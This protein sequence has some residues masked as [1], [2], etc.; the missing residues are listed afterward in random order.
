MTE[1]NRLAEVIF[2]IGRTLGER[3]LSREGDTRD[4]FEDAI[5]WAEE[6]EAAFLSDPQAS[7]SYCVDIEDFAVRKA[8]ANGF[9]VAE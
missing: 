2:D 1:F 4:D 5:S 9:E 7:E 6:F 8:L 3:R